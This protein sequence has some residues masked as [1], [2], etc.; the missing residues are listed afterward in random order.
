MKKIKFTKPSASLDQKIELLQE[1]WLI[2][3]NIEEA[4]HKQVLDLYVF[5]RK[6]RLLT[7]DA[8]EKIE[9][10]LKAS[11][12]DYMSENFWCFWYLDTTLFSLDK[13]EYKDLHSGFIDIVKRI[14]KDEKAI[15]VK[16]YFKYFKIRLF[17][18]NSK[19]L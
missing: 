14:Q 2:I 16:E 9:V 5:D 18:R 6:L 4:K 15:Y 13:K 3:E 19:K 8:I 7:L 11:I 17:K 12:N 1:R 10:S